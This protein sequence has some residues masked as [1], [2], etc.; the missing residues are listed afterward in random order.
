MSLPMVLLWTDSVA[1]DV[2]WIQAILVRAR[3]IKNV[4]IHECIFMV[5][6]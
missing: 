2:C 4:E 6:K 1:S 5:L 3:V